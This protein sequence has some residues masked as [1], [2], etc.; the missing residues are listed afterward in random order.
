MARQ[1]QPSEMAEMQVDHSATYQ[2]SQNVSTYDFTGIIPED[3][4]FTATLS[5]SGMTCAACILS[6]NEGVQELKFLED[7]SVSLLTHS[8]SIAFTGPQRN[9]D[10]II[11]KIED[12]GYDC[13]IE[14]IT[15][16]SGQ[17]QDSEHEERTVMISIAGMYSDC[18]PQSVLDALASSFPGHIS[19]DSPP[20]YKNPVMTITYRPKQEVITIRDILAAIRG[21]NDQIEATIYHRPTIEE[22]SRAMQLRERQRLLL[23]LFLNFI[24]AIPTFLIGVVWT[25]LVPS[26]DPIRVFFNQPIWGNGSTRAE[27]AL[28][29]LATLVMFFAADVFHIRAAKEIHAL[30]RRSS[31]VPIRRRFYRF[32]SMNLLMSA[33]TSVAYFPS[34]AVLGLDSRRTGEG[35][36]QMSTYFDAVVF[37]TMFILAG[38][39][40]EAYSKS[41]ASDAVTMLGRLRPVEALLERPTSDWK[42]S[43]ENF[44]QDLPRTSIEKVDVGLLEVGDVVRVLH[45]ASP[46]SDG[47]V[48]LGD[49]TFDESSLTG[50]THPIIKNLGDLV[51]TG[52]INTGKP[53]SV[54]VTGT[55]GASMIDQIV[56][57]V[58]EGQ[59]KRAPVERFADILTG[60]FV[61][62]ITL[63]AIS[64]FA[65]WFGLGQSGVLPESWRDVESGGWAFWALQFAIAVFVGACPC[66]IALAAPT[67]LFVGSGLAAQNGILVKGGGEAF[68]E[69]ST[70]DVVVFDKTGTLTEGGNPNVTDYDIKTSSV[71]EETIIWS[72]AQALEDSSTHP[73]AKAIAA[74]CTTR[75]RATISDCNITEIPGHGLKGVFNV[76]MSNNDTEYEAA[77]GN[78]AFIFSLGTPMDTRFSNNASRWKSSGKSIALLALRPLTASD[79]EQL[80]FRLAAQFAITDLLRPEAFSVIS[81]LREQGLSIWM[82]SGDN[83]TTAHA[84]GSQLG[85]PANNIIAGV[86]P[87]EKANKIRLLQSS[88]PKR[89]NKAGRA[90]VAMVGD[91]INDAPALDAADVGIAIGSGSDIAISSAKFVL[92][93][94]N[95]RALLMLIKLSRTVFRRVKFNF[96]WALVYNMALLPIAA[97]VIYPAHGHPRLNPVWAS[98]AMALSSLSVVCSSLAM[99]TTMLVVGF[100][101]AEDAGKV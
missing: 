52:T 59:A 64:A 79:E 81:G 56:Q 34:I 17:Q 51:F 68:Q 82:I 3:E 87:A 92:V 66:G 48:I 99:R 13:D 18:D 80:T 40:L 72:I 67:A 96:A 44:D 70:L 100:R 101:A 31:S 47:I 24:V 2:Q 38:R 30:W 9:I 32:G 6:I 73:I 89:H 4:K 55:S 14:N 16:V 76:L 63:L 69:A 50:E 58:R 42:G 5:I 15:Q 94:S 29:F 88:A 75:N 83:A 39:Y 7:I 21:L 8:A 61:P 28:F 54:R 74:F 78:E 22:R 27:W 33:G 10:H 25:S 57:V 85:I 46:P 98:L 35:R 53:I 20:S 37:L 36:N 62:A 12:R 1:L 91:G 23:R 45:G 60:Y 71:E 95:L 90:I 26:T 41:K 86:L 97:G 11:E 49:S 93:S 43:S 84:V 65:I 19:V 77:I